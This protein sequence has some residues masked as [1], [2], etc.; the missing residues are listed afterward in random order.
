MV[1]YPRS[2]VEVKGRGKVTHR[3]KAGNGAYTRTSRE[4]GRESK[5]L[6]NDVLS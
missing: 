1:V 3:C 2:A 4:G 5:I 6:N